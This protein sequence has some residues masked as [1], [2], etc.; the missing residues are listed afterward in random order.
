MPFVPGY[1]MAV[2]VDAIGADVAGFQLG[3]RVAALTVY[4]S[5]AELLVRKAEDFIP[6]PDTVSCRDAAAVILN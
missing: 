4:G 1:D 6:I 3:Q 5:F 2:V